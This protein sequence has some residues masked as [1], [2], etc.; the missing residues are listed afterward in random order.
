VSPWSALTASEATSAATV[1]P[2]LCA[3]AA[4]SAL[5]IAA[6]GSG[7]S[8]TTKSAS[9]SAGSS[10]CG[11]RNTMVCPRASSFA[12]RSRTSRTTIGSPK[13]GWKSS[14]A[15]SAGSVCAATASRHARASCWM[16][17]RRAA[18]T[19]TGRAGRPNSRPHP[20]STWSTRSSSAVSIANSG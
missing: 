14:I 17:F 3:S 6:S 12:R 5:S 19:L 2:A 1:S 18:V 7:H 15:K 4:K 11:D 9:S 8:S 20:A 16:S 13:K 10:T